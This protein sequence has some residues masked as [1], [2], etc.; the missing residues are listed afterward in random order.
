[1]EKQNL[2]NKQNLQTTCCVVLHNS[3]VKSLKQSDIE[4]L[5]G[6][7]GR[8]KGGGGI[9]F[10]VGDKFQLLSFKLLMTDPNSFTPQKQSQ[11]CRIT[12]FRTSFVIHYA[13][14]YEK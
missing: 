4:L 12:M 13:Q 11:R 6:K 8:K 2:N 7:L 5:T 3:C 1:M 10:A 14:R 9:T